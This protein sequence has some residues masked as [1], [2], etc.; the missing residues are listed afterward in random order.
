MERV[1]T[2]SSRQDTTK[3]TGSFLEVLFT[4]EKYSFSLVKLRFGHTSEPLISA[5][6]FNKEEQKDIAFTKRIKKIIPVSAEG[7][8]FMCFTI[9]N[10]E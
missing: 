7:H 4:Q 5:L 3:H 6:M 10:P 8:C 2:W 9:H 1:K